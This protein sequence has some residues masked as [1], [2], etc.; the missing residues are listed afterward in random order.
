MRMVL[1]FVCAATILMACETR[2]RDT[3]K[4]AVDDDSLCIKTAEF[5]KR[6]L[7]KANIEKDSLQDEL[8][9]LTTVRR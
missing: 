1:V 6:E 2:S 9:K 4:N 7:I 5:L 8:N 3:V